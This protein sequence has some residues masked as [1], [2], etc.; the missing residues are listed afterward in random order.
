MAYELHEQARVLCDK[1]HFRL[2]DIPPGT[3]AP[4]KK[5]WQ[6]NYFATTEEAVA[7][8]KSHPNHNM[9]VVLGPSRLCSLDIDD[10]R[11]AKMIL[12][13][14]NVDIESLR[15]QFPSVSGNP[16]RFRIFFRVPDGVELSR[17]A[18]SWPREDVPS[19]NATVFEFRSGDVQDVL[20][21][22]IHP[23]TQKPYQWITKPPKEGD[24]PTLPAIILN[25]WQNWNDFASLAKSLCPWAPKKESVDI[26]PAGPRR[27]GSSVIQ[28]WNDAHPDVRPFL[29][30]YGYTIDGKRYVSPHT[31]SFGAGVVVS[32]DYRKCFIHHASDP[33]GL[34]ATG[35]K[36]CGPFDL[37]CQYEH[38]GDVRQAVKAAAELMGLNERPKQRPNLTIVPSVSGG[39]EAPAINPQVDPMP[40]QYSDDHIASEFSEK[41]QSEL[42]YV[43]SWGR[44][45]RWETNR[46]EHDQ[47]LAAFDLVRGL[48]RTKA[49]DATYDPVLGKKAETVATK[50]SSKYTATAVETL[51]KADRRHA[52]TPDQWDKSPWHLNTPT[53]V[54][55]LLDGSVSPARRDGYMTKITKVGPSDM[56]CPT[57]L[58][59]LGK[60]TDGD[61]QLVEFMQR[62][63]GYCLTGSTRDHAMFFVYGTGGNGKGTFLNT[64]EWIMG[65]YS[66]VAGMETFTESKNDRHTTELA[67][68]MGARMVSA[69]ETEQGKRW[70]EARLKSLTGGDPITARFMRQDDFTFL[71][72]FKLVIAG[73]HKPSLRNV[74]EAMKR[75]LH[76]I[77]FTV[78]VPKS[79]RDPL[80][81]DKLRAEAPAILQWA[82]EGCL[83]WQRQGLN[84]PQAVLSAT[85]DY[86]VEQDSFGQ[87]ITD[88][89]ETHSAFSTPF[90]DL[91]KSYEEWSEKNGE[92][93]QSRKVFTGLLE[94][95]GFSKSK[96]GSIVVRGIRLNIREENLF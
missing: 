33:L 16:K 53:G 64:L 68:L 79:E 87:W 91:F 95:R 96:A 72:Q 36:P 41:F 25:L 27:E 60:A 55:N 54:V 82:I 38:G 89:C 34:D 76:L 57:W 62:M 59:F 31:T 61:N 4:N 73:N 63:A 20:P 42:R 44:W 13:E 40:I 6:K 56:G 30:K 48:C 81:M 10:V 58:A 37:F 18:L 15:D 23:D 22:S 47:T 28:Q 92:W 46:W 43:A 71:P 11:L 74:D 3:K 29:E 70:A 69:Q 12:S 1:F 66:S 9:G 32:S 21:P 52:A 17:K 80:L 90:M 75:R 26:I 45:M 86:L 14:V 83:E 50:L 2:I 67:R 24:F 7:F 51:A 39:S 94:Q 93:A 77:P 8:F 49:E 5:E 85:A 88:S 78:T 65:D 84:P 35:G 19:L